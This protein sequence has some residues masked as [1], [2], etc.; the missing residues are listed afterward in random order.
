MHCVWCQQKMVP[1]VS[2]RYLFFPATLDPLCQTC[3]STLKSISTVDCIGCGRQYSESQQVQGDLC[4][5]CMHWQ[6]VTQ[7]P[8]L[9]NR[10]VFHYNQSLST[11][12]TRWKYR[13]DYAIAEAFRNPIKQAFHQY[14]CHLPKKTI[15][16][17]VPLSNQRLQERAFN[18]AEALAQFLPLSMELLL[19]RT[20]G[21]KQAKKTKQERMTRTNPFQLIQQTSKPVLLID[22]IYTT[23]TTIY[24]AAT[25][26]KQGGAPIVCSLTL[27]R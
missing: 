21:E 17:P 4:S 18:Q 5:D 12:I 11:M 9:Q 6:K 19:K 1:E 3:Q 14:Y 23:G 26:V 16:V 13:G 15:V 2:W 20:H 25:K 27:A 24:H 7:Q 8:L 10:S 22:D